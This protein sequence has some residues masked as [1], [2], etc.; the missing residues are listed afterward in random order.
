[1]RHAKRPA[2]R[3]GR[4]KALVDLGR[5]LDS[6]GNPRIANKGP[7]LTP[8]QGKLQVAPFDSSAMLWHLL[9]RKA[10]ADSRR[11]RCLWAMEAQGLPTVAPA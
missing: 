1:L 2:R 3:S 6:N 9:T 5:Q 7:S 8:D 4:W 11:K 10:F